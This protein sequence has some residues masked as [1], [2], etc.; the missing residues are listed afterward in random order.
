MQS[1]Q[2]A[3]TQTYRRAHLYKMPKTAAVTTT[4][5]VAASAQ[6]DKDNEIINR[7]FITIYLFNL[8]HSTVSIVYS[9]NFI[10]TQWCTIYSYCLIN[11]NF[12]SMWMT[13]SKCAQSI[14][15]FMRMYLNQGENHFKVLQFSVVILLNIEIVRWVKWITTKLFEFLLNYVNYS[16]SELL[17]VW[18][19]LHIWIL[20]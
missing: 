19:Y 15:L 8:F 17:L 9:I 18:S 7:Y 20:K 5:M 1:N 14:Y 4:K 10:A 12:V 2:I 6:T 13:H 11:I 3:D 16:N